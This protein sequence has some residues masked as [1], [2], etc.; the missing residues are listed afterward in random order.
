MSYEV[1]E[2]LPAI[3]NPCDKNT[4]RARIAAAT[5]KMENPEI[6]YIDIV[7]YDQLHLKA[8]KKPNVSSNSLRLF[9]KAN[10]R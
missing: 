9:I 8:R 6:K 3:S 10:Y 7:H 1:L 2:K 5:E 4:I